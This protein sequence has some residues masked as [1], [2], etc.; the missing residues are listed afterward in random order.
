MKSKHKRGV[1]ETPAS[2]DLLK[3][4]GYWNGERFVEV[5]ML[6]PEQAAERF[7]QMD[8]WLEGTEWSIPDR[9]RPLAT[10]R[11]DVKIETSTCH[12]SRP[13]PRRRSLMARRDRAPRAERKET[14]QPPPASARSAQTSVCDRAETAA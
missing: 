14:P 3:P 1:D 7:A 13:Q 11:Q 6:T 8:E 4:P 2:F 5:R 9:F 10:E 12:V